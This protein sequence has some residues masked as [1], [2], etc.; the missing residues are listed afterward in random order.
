ML[1]EALQP[2]VPVKQAPLSWRF[3]ILL[4]PA[5]IGAGIGA[6]LLMLFL[7]AVQHF[8]WSYETGDFLSAVERTSGSARVGIL[9]LGGLL[10]GG[11]NWLIQRQRGGSS[12]DLSEAVWFRS[13]HMPLLRT[14]ERAILSITIVGMGASIGRETA[15]KMLGA[16]VANVLSSWSRLGDAERRLLV[17]CGAGAGMGAVYNVPLGGALFALEVLLGTLSL[18]LVV[19]AFATS[20]IATWVSWLL[21]PNQPTYNIPD[22]SVSPGLIVWAIMA[23]PIAGMAAAIYV[24]AIVWGDAQKPSGLAALILPA[25]IFTGLGL[26][27]LPFPQLL[28]NGKDAVERAFFGEFDLRLLL[29]LLLLKPLATSACLA[30]GAPGGLFMPTLTCGAMLGGALGTIWTML[31]PGAPLGTYAIVGAG[32]LLAAAM[33]SPIAAIVLM[34]E[35]APGS[36]KLVVPLML[37][38]AGAVSTAGLLEMR[39][40]YSGRIQR[41]RSNIRRSD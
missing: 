16:A 25:V 38:I 12:T 24:R 28:G 7:R 27:A 17:A 11:A 26:L 5:G 1:Q 31:W 13:G 35:L 8:F 18:P 9:F 29:F 41:L 33:Q 40:I 37:A 21:I 30:S 22:Y 10:A 39:S 14:V 15:P 2:N 34:I 4:V 6:G 3:L 20:L 23:G 19:P 36:I 32:A